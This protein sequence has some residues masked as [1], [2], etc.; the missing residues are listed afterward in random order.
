M[1]LFRF[2]VGKMSRVFSG[3]LL[4]ENPMCQP[5]TEL[6]IQMKQLSD[7]DVQLGTVIFSIDKDI[8]KNAITRTASSKIYYNL[9]RNICFHLSEENGKRTLT[10]YYYSDNI[11]AWTI[12]YLLQEKTDS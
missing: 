2:F 5:V 4:P 11:D 6:E 8:M 7:A 12:S 10:G 9:E 1:G 3:H